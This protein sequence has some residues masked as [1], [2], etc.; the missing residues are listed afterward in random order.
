MLLLLDGSCTHGFSI[1]PARTRAEVI[2]S[3]NGIRFGTDNRIEEMDGTLRGCV[4]A[5]PPQR[6]KRCVGVS[7][8]THFF[9]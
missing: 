5:H 4:Y 2:L 7:C 9:L 8:A 3:R 1:S 6:L